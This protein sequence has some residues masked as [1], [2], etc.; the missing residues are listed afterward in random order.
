M[1]VTR[2]PKSWLFF[3]V[4][5]SGAISCWIAVFQSEKSALAQPITPATDNTQTKVN[6]QGNQ[7]NITGGSL[8]DDKVNLFQSFQEFGLS[9]GQIANFTSNSSIKNI[10][11]RVVGGNPSL[12]NGLIQVSG[13][14]S[15]LYLMNPAGVVFGPNS[16][17][18]VTASFTATTATGIALKNSNGENN[19]FNAFGENNYLNLNGTPSQFAFDLATAGSIINAGN[20][21]VKTG[22]SLT[23][24]GGNVINTGKLTAPG[25]NIILAAVPG[26]SLV[27]LSQSGSLLSLEIAPPRDTQGLLLPITPL[28]L[29]ALLTGNKANVATGLTVSSSGE[30]QLTSSGNVIPTDGKTVI[31]SGTIDV[32]NSSPGPPLPQ[33][34][35]SVYL[36][37]DKVGVVNGKINASGTNGGGTVLIGGDSEGKGTVPNAS[38]TVVTTDSV[39]NAD[40][41][42]SGNGGRVILWADK[43]T[44]FFGNISAR[45][46]NK[47]GDGGFVETSAKE[48]LI[49]DGKVNLFA[50]NG[51]LGTL[52]LDPTN[53]TIS[54]SRSSPGVDSQLNQTAQILATNFSPTSINISQSTLQALPSQANV[55]LEATDKITIGTLTGNVL[56][57]KAGL[58]G[59]ITFKAGGDFSMNSDA[60]IR[61]LSRNITISGANI[62]VGNIDTSKSKSSSP[63]GNITLNSTG[64]IETGLLNSSGNSASGGNIFLTAIDDILTSSIDS[65]SLTTGNGGKI[66]LQSNN[67]AITT[68]GSLKSD[69]V[70]GNGGAIAF[71]AKGDIT[72]LSLSSTAR[73]GSGGTISLTSD[74]GAINTSAGTLDSSHTFNQSPGNGG[75][76]KLAAANG[77]TVADIN[78]NTVAT[79]SSSNGGKV[80]LNADRNKI[81]LSGDINSSA[82]GGTGG[83]L[84]IIGNVTLSQSNTTLNTTGNTSGGDITFN[85]PIN[86]KTRGKQ[87]LTLNSGS[88]EITFNG[89][90]NNV[91]LGNLT[92]N[93]TGNVRLSGDYF[94]TNN[95]TFNNPVNFLS[96]TII[97][98]EN[99]I[100]FNNSITAGTNNISLIS[101]EINFANKVS[102][103]GDLTIKPF[104]E[105][106]NIAIGGSTDTGSDTLNLLSSDIS[107]LQNGFKSITI[108]NAAHTGTITLAGNATFNDPLSLLVGDGL[109][110]TKGFTLTGSDNA[111]ISLQANKDITTG[112]INTVGQ[113][114]TLTTSKGNIDSSSG[115]LSTQN[116][117]GKG[118]DIALTAN[119]GKIGTGNLNSTGTLDGGK[120]NLKSSGDIATG[121][122]QSLSFSTI[123]NNGNGGEIFIESGGNINTG[124]IASYSRVNSQNS[125]NAGKGGSVTLNAKNAKSNIT[126]A[127]SIDSSSQVQ[128]GG[129]NSNIGG[130]INLNTAN[131]ISVTGS[132]DSS[133]Q[134]KAGAGNSNTG[135][136]IN[137]NTANNI[138]VGG[139]VDSSSQ[140]KAGAGNSN[141]GGQITLNATNGKLDISSFVNTQSSAVSGNSGNG[142]A[143]AFSTKGDITTTDLQSLSRGSGS[144]GVITLTSTEGK[145]NSRGNLNSSS[146]S[147][148]G[149]GGA[150][151]LT[152]KNI[153]TNN[154]ESFA[155]GAGKGGELTINNRGET[156][157]TGNLNS[158][159]G[160][161]GGN[162]QFQGST[163]I[164][165][166]QIN[167]SSTA[168]KGG[169]VTLNPSSDLQFNYINAQGGTTG[170]TVNISSGRYLRATGI[171]QDKNG[172]LASISTA[173]DTRGGDITIRHGGNG[174]VPFSVGSFTTIGTAGSITT[175]NST[176]APDKSFLYTQNLENI[177]IISVNRPVYSI[178]RVTKPNNEPK[179]SNDS[180]K[181]TDSPT[182]ITLPVT[183]NI[184]TLKTA[185][186]DSGGMTKIEQGVTGVFEKYLGVS[187]API[188]TLEQ[189]KTSLQ[190]IEKI[191]GLK[192]ALIYAFFTPA[193]PQAANF[194]N[195]KPNQTIWQFSPN[196]FNTNAEHL[197][198]QNQTPQDT[199]QL[200]LVVVTSEGTLIRRKVEGAT[201]DS[202]LAT[203]KEFLRTVTNAR[204]RTGYLAPAQQMYQW[205]IAPIEKDL[206]AKRINNL[207]FI[208]DT[209]LRS[210]P[211]AAMHDGQQFL[212]EKYSVGL[213][214]S[215]SLTDTRYVDLRKTQVLA[216][217]AEKF[218]DQRSLPGVPVE[219][220]MIV[221]KLW[222]G[223]TFL[224]ENFTLQNLKQ[225]RKIQPFGII[226]L[227]THGE[228]QAGQLGNSYIQLWDSKLPLDQLRQLEWDKPPVELLV[229]SACRTALGDEQAELGFAGLAVRA[230]V[231]SAL[232]SLWSVSDEGTL[233]LMTKFYEQLKEAPIKAEAL[234]RAQLAM[235]KGEVRLQ[236]GKLVTKNSNLS[237]PPELVKLGDKDLSH[238]YYWSSFTLIGN[239]W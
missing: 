171:F 193:N 165:V 195:T 63:G 84:S 175:G 163:Q 81:N 73:T 59:S 126:V 18:N 118:G 67:G 228:F 184:P 146:S 223:K 102:G 112:N 226:H 174:L 34:G 166:G 64:K 26:T 204:N 76:I 57:F 9:Q 33:I 50:E 233:G 215:L 227:A 140:V 229:L 173:G 23:L 183:N 153:T 190:R 55:I 202:V 43:L 181:K 149:S 172:T 180:N 106:Q 189:A 220:S 20:L 185:S 83:D 39:I 232:G 187:D 48:D 208:M 150:I 122:I 27:R 31:A 77:I 179:D 120:I 17:L 4:S 89:I 5:L 138:S 37:G 239:P 235:L 24:V 79:S 65:R 211:I 217:G 164:T 200:E 197:L 201:R 107:A 11:G 210:I 123:G 97:K 70:S 21:K 134:V 129:G 58:G 160:V 207:A 28:N 196:G 230:G 3:I 88:G 114:I 212:V 198:S 119:S 47:S 69:G 94:C 133:S 137:L 128:T 92:T 13:G 110:N 109:I 60:T 124:N 141:N 156:I 116:T 145:I 8:S 12:I 29:A 155:S 237:L 238:P 19:W 22:E 218:T 41:E 78:S 231:K 191:T 7:F 10:L 61:A 206:Q 148:S 125:A 219:L 224:N 105:K 93:G 176:I 53:I 121:N 199:D 68:Q 45:G 132:V 25:G 66:T 91:P 177:Q 101:N 32:S 182:S 144:G 158:S 147:A 139:S 186:A 82:S 203:A 103:T 169:N 90:G 14:N 135:G 115:T 80:T 16:Q 72:T 194:Q 151:V 136:A 234:R 6:Q 56:T 205:L 113:A 192:P 49:F 95:C 40:A 62:K 225:A 87:D 130:A 221:G 236:S 36:L 99:T 170:G 111:T 35:G 52:L 100:A 15:N 142:G 216:M 42:E 178:Y 157:S 161:Q 75:E 131:N 44:G 30:V 213:M 152:G 51:N 214:P 222:Q 74:S 71:N 162:I 2:K 188:V 98:A 143:I 108:G 54:N 159:G 209:G 168:G 104:N 167:S 127:G 96:N 1:K 154:I 38:R 117:T 86:G 46:G 85:N